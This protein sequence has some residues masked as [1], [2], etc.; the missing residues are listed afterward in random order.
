MKHIPVIVEIEDKVG[1]KIKAYW[2][3]ELNDHI[4]FRKTM[5]ISIN[6]KALIGADMVIIDIVH[7]GVRIF[8]NTSDIK[9]SKD[10]KTFHGEVKYYYPIEKWK[11]WF[12]DPGWTKKITED[13]E[14]G[15]LLLPDGN[16]W[17]E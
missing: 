12:G 9:T 17:G 3:Q 1:N 15:N 11:I 7:R 14:K 6:A 5:A 2:K 16:T 10:V 4:L 13:L 8:A